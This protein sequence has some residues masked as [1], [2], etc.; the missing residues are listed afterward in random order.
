MT[1]ISGAIRGTTLYVNIQEYLQLHL[2][3][4][5]TGFFIS[6][7]PECNRY[8]LIYGLT[9]ICFDPDL[10]FARLKSTGFIFMR[11]S[12]IV[13]LRPSNCRKPA[14]PALSEL[15]P[16]NYHEDARNASDRKDDKDIL[17]P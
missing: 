5:R 17:A 15:H 7:L 14:S 1:S 2:S 6:G 3:C 8:I 10:L 4:Q 13:F 16:C 12:R 9:L 11:G